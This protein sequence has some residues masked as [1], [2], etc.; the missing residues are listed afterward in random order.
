MGACRGLQGPAVPLFELMV[1]GQCMVRLKA[2]LHTHTADD[3]YDDV[4]YSSEM[5]I[6][7]AAQLNVEVL[8]FACHRKLVV[9][10]R[11]TE[12]ARR[13]GIVLVPAVELLVEGKH[14]VALNPDSSQAAATTFDQLRALGRRNAAF[15]APHPFYLENSCLGRRLIENIDLFDAIEYCTLYYYG[16]NPNR[17]AVR[18]AKRHG[19][20]M[21][22]TSD[23]HAW[24]YVG[25]TFSW[26]DCEDKSVEGVVDAI[27]R[28]RVAVET[29]PQGFKQNA[30]MLRS[31]VH[32][33]L[34]I[35]AGLRE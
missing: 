11:L 28:G 20:P 29:R 31:F 7:A 9:Y 4:G 15:L 22:G 30:R 35:L 12:Y 25:K 5:L 17:R 18:V 2:D 24:P 23:L 34:R 27:R 16:I 13:R 1:E 14:V 6:D 26:L 32:E 3:P 8:A 19:L 33:K 10:P 21:L